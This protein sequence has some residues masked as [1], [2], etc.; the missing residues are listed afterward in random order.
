MIST[1]KTKQAEKFPR[2]IMGDKRSAAAEECSTSE[3]VIWK[4]AKFQ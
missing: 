1:I 4:F 2:G 3:S